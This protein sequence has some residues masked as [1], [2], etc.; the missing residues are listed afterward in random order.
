MKMLATIVAAVLLA[1]CAGE[2]SVAQSGGVN[3]GAAAEA[4]AQ[5]PY[6][7]R[8]KIRVRPLYPYRRYHSLYPTPYAVEYPGPNAH[9]ECVSRYVTEYRASGPVVVPRMRCWWVPGKVRF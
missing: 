5:Q 1:L 8:P 7:V 3:A 9:R 2:P 4:L 6:R